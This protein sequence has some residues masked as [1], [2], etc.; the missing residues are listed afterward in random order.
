MNPG[1][2]TDSGEERQM[3]WSEPKLDRSFFRGPREVCERSAVKR[4]VNSLSSGT[5]LPR[6]TITMASSK[7]LSHRSAGAVVRG[8]NVTVC[9]RWTYWTSPRQSRHP[10]VGIAAGHG[11]AEVLTLRLPSDDQ[12]LK[13]HAKT[14]VDELWDALVTGG[15]LTSY[16]MVWNME[17]GARIVGHAAFDIARCLDPLAGRGA[18]QPYGEESNLP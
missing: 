1:L 16:A 7:K 10:R 11:A 3:L 18:L 2:V 9:C 8:V 6:A 15:D 13:L 14:L 4:A 17:M 12:H 5:G